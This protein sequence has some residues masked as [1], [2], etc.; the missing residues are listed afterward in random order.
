[1]KLL[2]TY[3]EWIEN[4]D[5]FQCL[6]ERFARSMALEMKFDRTEEETK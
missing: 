5:S 2:C 4:K 1:M 6:S 3:E